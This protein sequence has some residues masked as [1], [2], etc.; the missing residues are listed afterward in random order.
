MTFPGFTSSIVCSYALQDRGAHPSSNSVQ[1]CCYWPQTCL[2]ITAILA[3]FWLI[4]TSNPQLRHPPA[5]FYTD[6]LCLLA[7]PPL[8]FPV[9]ELP[10]RL[11]QESGGGTRKQVPGIRTSLG[12]VAVVTRVAK[13]VHGTNNIRTTYCWL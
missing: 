5:P 7:D 6:I 1:K 13:Y 3:S 10:H 12:D 11:L 2:T 4:L 9:A 8:G